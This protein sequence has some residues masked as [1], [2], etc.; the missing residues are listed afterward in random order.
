M[1]VGSWRFLLPFSL[2]FVLYH[3][4]EKHKIAHPEGAPSSES[5]YILKL[6]LSIRS[7]YALKCTLSV[8]ITLCTQVETIRQDHSMHSS[9]HHPSGSLYVL[10][11]EL[12]ENCPSGRRRGLQPPHP[13]AKNGGNLARDMNM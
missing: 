2:L 13:C 1:A 7:L 10:K 6:K 4:H 5:L 12:S 8:R 3:N 9:A 11:L